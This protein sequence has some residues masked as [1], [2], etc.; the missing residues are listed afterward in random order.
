M[1]ATYEGAKQLAR[2]LHQVLRDAEVKISLHEC[3]L[4]MARGGGYRDWH[5]LRQCLARGQSDKPDLDG[6]LERAILSLPS[7]AVGPATRWIDAQLAR[8]NRD[9]AGE[10]NH[11][12]AAN[13]ARIWDF[14]VSIQVLHRSRTP[15]FMRGSGAGLL[16]RLSMLSKFSSVAAG[17][18]ID[19]AT[20]VSNL[21]GELDVLLAADMDHPCFGREFRRLC[22]ANILVW[23]PDTL[24]LCLMPPPV[25]LVR[26]HVAEMRQGYAEYWREAALRRLQPTE[27]R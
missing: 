8:F 4:A 15:L 16:L 12:D 11:Q 23:K 6:F 9:L 17:A 21:S 2:R 25:E 7:H 18:R 14:V 26:A 19:V 20:L 10:F 1:Y 5:H 22:A 3:L 27:E 13:V 24:T